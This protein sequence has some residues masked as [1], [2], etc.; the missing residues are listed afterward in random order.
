MFINP[1]KFQIYIK[2]GITDMRK[3]INGL[4]AMVQDEMEIDIFSNT[5]ILFCGRNRKLLKIIYWERNG[6]CLLQKRLEKQ[7]FPW[8]K[9]SDAARKLTFEELNWLLD[10]IDFFDAHFEVKYASV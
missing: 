9:D 6:F 2:P 7:K 8:P 5:I 10:G 3:A 4:S 1:E